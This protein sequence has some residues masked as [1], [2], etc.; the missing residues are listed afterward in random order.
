[1][2]NKKILVK[3][4]RANVYLDE[5][6]LPKFKALYPDTMV[7]GEV[8]PSSDALSA[9]IGLPS[10]FVYVERGLAVVAGKTLSIGTDFSW[11]DSTGKRIYS[12]EDGVLVGRRD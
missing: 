8:S 2:S 6:N 9:F 10:F 12:F 5:K 11:H 3:I 1:M 4:R 7:I